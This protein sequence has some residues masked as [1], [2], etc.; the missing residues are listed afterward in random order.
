MSGRVR[1]AETLRSAGLCGMVPGFQ[2][3]F[4]RDV[5][6][7]GARS[8]PWGNPGNRADQGPRSGAGRP[9]AADQTGMGSGSRNESREI[10]EATVRK[11]VG[12]DQGAGAPLERASV[13]DRS[14]IT[15]ADVGGFA[16]CREIC[17]V[18]GVAILAGE[19]SMSVTDAHRRGVSGLLRDAERG[20]D[21]VVERHGHAVAAILSVRRLGELSARGGSSE[22]GV[23]AG[24]RCR[25]HRR[26][27]GSRRAM[28]ALGFDRAEL[29]AELDAESNAAG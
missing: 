25:G 13:G 27:D 4:R 14:S 5:A 17:T 28:V 6:E 3:V 19:H 20:S 1:P 26:T 18:S 21:I 16:F 7:N 9:G 23:G 12:L 24:A 15:V 10:C 11:I 22:R 8:E 2:D 29:E